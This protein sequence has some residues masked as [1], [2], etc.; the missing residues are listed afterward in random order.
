M[1]LE[2]DLRACSRHPYV[3]IVRKCRYICA[4]QLKKTV[5]A[6]QNFPVRHSNTT[7]LSSD[8]LYP[9]RLCTP[10]VLF[11]LMKRQTNI[12][13]RPDSASTAAVDF[14]PSVDFHTVCCLLKS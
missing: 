3:Y 5:N 9:R 14:I 8:H 6:S 2:V 12:A 1:E 4:E 10:Q 11:E 7:R 13:T